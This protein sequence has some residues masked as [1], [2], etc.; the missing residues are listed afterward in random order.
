M[1]KI[2]HFSQKC[3]RSNIKGRKKT[4]VKVRDKLKIFNVVKKTH[5]IITNISKEAIEKVMYDHIRTLCTRK[6]FSVNM[7]YFNNKLKKQ[8]I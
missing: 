8:N 4:L 6:C 5:E 2:N 3:D 7:C 1:L